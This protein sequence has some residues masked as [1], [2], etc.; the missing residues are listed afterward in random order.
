M[1]FSLFFEMQIPQPTRERE[2]QIFRD[3]VAQAERADDLGFHAVWNV[4]HHGL[5]EYSQSSA[6]ETFLAFVAARTTQVRLGHG[7][8]LTP[9]RY[10]HPIRVAERTATL[11]ILS[12]GRVNLGTGK[13]GTPTE[14]DAFQV[15]RGDLR[16]EWLEAARMIPRMWADDVFWWDGEHYQVPPIQICPKPVQEPHPPLFSACSTPASA[17]DA[18]ALGMGALNFA[19]G[20]L[21]KLTR[22]VADYRAAAATAEPVGLTTTTHFACTPMSLVLDSDREACEL[23]FRGADYFAASQRSYYGRERPLG[24]INADRGPIPEDELTRRMRARGNEDASMTTVVGDAAAASDQVALFA[25]AG[26]D[27]LIMVM[28]TGSV[29]HEAVMRSIELFA[30]AVMPKFQ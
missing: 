26:V 16:S 25:E 17:V 13:S 27:E 11:D 19:G 4:E 6:P 20:T 24:A 12:E 21:R 14:Q 2:H 29:P 8:A 18:A 10:N 5:R 23:G 30:T 7:V 28:Q 3:C 15:A 9:G 1:R 22:R